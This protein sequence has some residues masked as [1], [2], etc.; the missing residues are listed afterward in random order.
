MNLRQ[1]AAPS[2]LVNRIKRTL[3]AFVLALRYTLRGDK[4]PL[5]R[6]RDQ[7]PALAAWWGKTIRLVEAVERSANAS[8]I[9]PAGMVLNIDR[10]DISMTTIL[11]TVKYHAERE[12]PYLMAHDDPYGA[13]TLQATNFNDRYLV[14][15]LAQKIDTPLK[16]SVEALEQHLGNMPEN[17][18]ARKV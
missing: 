2:S 3:R 16:A 8:D 12:F 11:Q 18:S 10:R 15:Q 13:I 9:D 14:Q 17:S 1:N 7:Y 6:V 4:P 5:L